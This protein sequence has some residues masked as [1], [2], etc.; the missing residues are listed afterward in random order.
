MPI[1]DEL[2]RQG[3][4]VWLASDGRAYR[5]LE[6]E[7]PDLPLLEL[8]AYNIRYGSGNMA[9]NIA[10]QMPKILWAMERERRALRQIIQTHDI[11]GVISD[12]RFGCY[13]TQ[14]PCVFLTHQINLIVPT[15]MGLGTFAKWN[16]RRL[17]SRYQECW[18]PDAAGEPN[19]SGSLSHGQP[20]ANARYIGP[21]SR[22]QKMDTKKHYDIIA[23]LSGPEPQRSYFEEAILRQAEKMPHRFLIVKGKTD[24]EERTK[25]GN[26]ETVAYMTKNELNEAI[27]ASDIVLTRS[28][29][30]TLMDLAAMGKQRVILV[31]TPGQTEQEYLADIF[32]TKKIFL[33]EKQNTLNLERALRQ[34]DTCIGL[35]IKADNK[36][37]QRAIS[38]FLE[39][40]A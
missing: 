16:N 11:Q 22:M 24:S 10:P 32:H 12:N 19:L 39:Q 28:G 20:L 2:R 4:E 21:L 1:V 35:N 37:L 7:Y 31:P 9:W 36:A 33:C 38:S 40:I 27:M 29:Y 6:K 18:I 13:S 15:L 14:V 34:V 26:I 5:L 23:V 25:S 3:A 8:P 30:S 17:I